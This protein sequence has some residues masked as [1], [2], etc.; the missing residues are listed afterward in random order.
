M[1]ESKPRK[2]AT[3]TPPPAKAAAPKPNAP[4]FV[5]V[6]LGLMIVGLAWIV[7][8]YLSGWNYPIPG[9]RGWNLA[10]GFSLILGGFGMTTRW[11]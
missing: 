1:P 8:T 9:I 10:I 5:P 2:K 11:R 4:W 7:V 3:Y 6:M